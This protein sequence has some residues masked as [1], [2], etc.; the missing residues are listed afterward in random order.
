MPHI[1]LVIGKAYGFTLARA[2]GCDCHYWHSDSTLVARC[3]GG[4]RRRRVEYLVLTS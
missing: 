3:S 1:Q 4:A 2:I